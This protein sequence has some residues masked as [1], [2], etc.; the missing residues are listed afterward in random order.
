M[1]DSIH[2]YWLPRLLFAGSLGCAGGL[3]LV[4]LVAP[5]LAGR[6][7]EPA[8]RLFA[9]DVAVRRTALACA[10][11]LAVTAFVFFRPPPAPRVRKSS[12]NSPPG[13][14]AGA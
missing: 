1:W 9:E 3:A 13:N 10:A 8:G 4:V 12:R 7:P 6:L 14:V 11:G 2:N 5:W